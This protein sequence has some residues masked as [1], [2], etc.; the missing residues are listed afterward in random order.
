MAAS[1]T[2]QRRNEM[3]TTRLRNGLCALVFLV[4]LSAGCSLIAKSENPP[5]PK[6]TKSSLQNLYMDYLKNEGYRPEV[7]SDGD[8]E[9]KREGLTYFIV[10]DP[11]DPE[12]FRLVLANIWKIDDEAE[13]QKVLAS[14]DYSNAKSKVSKVYTVKDN[15]WVSIEILVAHPEDFK[16]VFKRSLSALTNGEQ[17]FTED[18][19]KDTKP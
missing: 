12:C 8:V 6:V 4:T 18:M 13:R 1:E 17:N 14:A 16:A 5:A 7:D 9:F 11:D 19:R 2:H 10:V 3:K 15:V